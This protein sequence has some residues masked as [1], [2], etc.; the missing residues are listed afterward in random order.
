MVDKLSFE[1]FTST[2]ESKVRD[3]L[4]CIYEV[5]SINVIKNNGISLWGLCI[6]CDGSNIAPNIYLNSYYESYM[7][8][9]DI[10]ELVQDVL[11]VYSQSNKNMPSMEKNLD[12]ESIKYDIIFNLVNYEMNK[13]MLMSSPFKKVFGNLA[14]TFHI[15]IGSTV[16]GI[17]TAVINNELFHTFNVTLEHLYEIA[18]ENTMRWFPATIRNMNDVICSIMEEALG[19]CEE[20]ERLCEASNLIDDGGEMFVL[21]NNTGIN[22]ATAVLYP[23]VIKKISEAFNTDLYIIPSSVHEIILVLGYERDFDCNMLNEMVRDINTSQ[24]P[25]ED[26]LGNTVYMFERSINAIISFAGR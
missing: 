22:G 18:L 20:F 14:V 11:R 19:G 8:G 4:G 3:A 21:S 25:K 17:S 10:E 7:N 5:R 16:E 6:R 13:E 1:N 23:D 2:M 9:K 24:V 15:L 12:W 26:V